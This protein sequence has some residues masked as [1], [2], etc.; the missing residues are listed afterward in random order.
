MIQHDSTRFNTHCYPSH[1]LSRTIHS[2]RISTPSIQS[3]STRSTSNTRIRNKCK[4][5]RQEESSG[6]TASTPIESNRIFT[7]STPSIQYPRPHDQPATHESAI[8]GN[9]CVRKNVPPKQ[10]TRNEYLPLPLL[11]HD[12][13]ATHESTINGNIGV[14]KNVPEPT[15]HSFHAETIIIMTISV[16]RCNANNNN[17]LP[18]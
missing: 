16:A 11:P 4:C 3:P 15:L 1:P 7:P 12:Q 13:P 2:N 14:R 6:T 10:S 9:I 5:L 18:Y 8:N 17:H